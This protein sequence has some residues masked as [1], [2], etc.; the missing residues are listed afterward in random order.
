MY[1]FPHV[2][3]IISWLNGHFGIYT[4]DFPDDIDC[5]IALF[6]LKE[7]CPDTLAY[8]ALPGRQL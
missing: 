6:E 3:I 4:Y 8:C 1:L 7:A 5:Q 2:L